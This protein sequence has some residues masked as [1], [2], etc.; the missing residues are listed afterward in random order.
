MNDIQQIYLSAEHSAKRE[1][2]LL[3]LQLYQKHNYIE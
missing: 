2:L 1:T 3:V